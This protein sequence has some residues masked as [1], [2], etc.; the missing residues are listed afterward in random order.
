MTWIGGTAPAARFRCQAKTR[1]RQPDQG[2]L[3]EM[4]GV[5]TCT[6]AFDVPQRAVT[7]GQYVVL[8]S[9][10]TCLG[11]GVI[12]STRPAEALSHSA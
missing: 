5:D 11:G 3:V 12:D 4:T 1:Y 7:P 10:D 6:V 9:G 2:A 8:Y